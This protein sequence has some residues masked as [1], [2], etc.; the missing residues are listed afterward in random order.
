MAG[1][2]LVGWVCSVGGVLGGGVGHCSSG[3]AYVGLT[4]EPE[5]GTGLIGMIWEDIIGD[6][7]LSVVGRVRRLCS[8]ALPASGISPSHV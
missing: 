1:W 4:V 8:I 5:T 7:L 3:L 2:G 6:G